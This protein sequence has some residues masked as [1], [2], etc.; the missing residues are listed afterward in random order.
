LK[1]AWRTQATGCGAP[2]EHKAAAI[3]VDGFITPETETS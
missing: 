3:V 2:A 1:W